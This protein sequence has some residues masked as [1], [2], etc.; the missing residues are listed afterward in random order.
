MKSEW[1]IRPIVPEEKLY[2]FSQSAQ[3]DAQTGCVGQ[4]RADLEEGADRFFTVWEDRR[5]PLKTEVFR[6]DLNRI[7]DGFRFSAPPGGFLHDLQHLEC[8]CRDHPEASLGN[9]EGDFGFRADTYRYSY[10]VRLNPHRGVC[11]AAVCCYVRPQLDIHLFHAGRGIRFVDSG[12]RELFRVADGDSVR[13]VYAGGKTGEYVCRY[14][15]DYHTEL[16]GECFHIHE[17]AEILERGGSRAEPAPP[18]RGR[19]AG[20]S[21][22]PMN[23]EERP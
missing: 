14:V 3:I 21:A 17:L 15:D 5:Q 10:L 8:F 11:H 19:T 18:P 2:L 23:R 4:L 7:V 16:N 13:I 6:E 1:T 22:Q 9:T 20:R 12:Y